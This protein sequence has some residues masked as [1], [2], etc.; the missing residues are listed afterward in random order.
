MITK[1]LIERFLKNECSHDEYRMVSEYLAAHPEELEQFLPVEE[2]TGGEVVPW[3][4]ERSE[5]FFQSI[6]NRLFDRSVLSH[7]LKTGLAAASVMLVIVMVWWL[8]KE[9]TNSASVTKQASGKNN[10]LADRL[11]R[12][13]NTT[14]SVLT[15]SLTDGSTVELAPNSQ[16]EYSSAFS[17]KDQRSIHLQGEALF[18]VAKDKNRPFKVTSGDLTTTVLGTSFTVKAF[19]GEATIQVRLYTGKVVV[20]PSLLIK[21][22]MDSNVFLLPGQELTYNKQLM[23]A[24]VRSTLKKNNAY[25]AVSTKRKGQTFRQPDW[26]MFGGQPLPQVF[27]QLS[28]YY[29]VEINYYPA[30]V[31]NRYFTGK[32]AKTDSLETILKDISLLHGLSLKKTDGVYIFRKK[33]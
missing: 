27:D 26:Y 31:S 12:R 24:S 20:S 10:T 18:T 17:E 21:A 16:I 7:R 23:T 14:G 30:D 19:D 22:K 4:K 2:F 25:A 15:F 3:E 5:H 32:F 13:M 8:S 1:E 28:E 11:E 6:R 29:G 9:K 33:I